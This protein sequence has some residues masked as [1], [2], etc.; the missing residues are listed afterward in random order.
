VIRCL[1]LLLCLP[2]LAA[3]ACAADSIAGPGLAS[4][5]QPEVSIQAAPSEAVAPAFYEGVLW[6]CRAFLYAPITEPLYIVDGV[7][8]PAAQ[9]VARLETDDIQSIEVVTGEVAAPLYG[10]RAALGAV[11]IATRAAASRRR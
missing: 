5:P 6:R 9:A 8:T 11:I 7:I 2:L 3:T 4:E 1:R 10:S